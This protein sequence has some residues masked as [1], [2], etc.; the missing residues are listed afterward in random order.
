MERKYVFRNIS[1]PMTSERRNFVENHVKKNG[2]KIGAYI[3]LL[4]DEDMAK[5]SKSTRGGSK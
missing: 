3:A 4:I 5:K 2:L 1:V